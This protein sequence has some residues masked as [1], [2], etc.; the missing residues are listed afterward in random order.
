[1]KKITAMLLCLVLV[2]SLCACGAKENLVGTWKA[3]IELADLMNK[4]IAASGDEAMAEA[5]NLESFQLPLIL[6]LR[7]DGT[8]TMKVDPEAMAASADKLAADLT[9]G[10]KAYFVTMLQQQGLEVEDPTEFLT[11]MGLDLDALVAEMKDQFLSEETFA[12][13]TMESKYKAEDGKI[14]FSDDLES[15]I[16]ADEYNTYTLK[17][18]TL[19][20]DVGNMVIEEGQE[21][22]AAYMFPMTLTRVK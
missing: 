22:M 21:D 19:T 2:L 17:G 18:D 8:C 15:E 10:L 16:N 6:E 1:M 13:F 14:Y 7:E 4:E 9:E 20:L 5:M 3:N 12:E 11:T